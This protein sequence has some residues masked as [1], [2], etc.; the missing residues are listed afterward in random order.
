MD[1]LKQLQELL[2]DLFQRE[3][4]DLDFSLYRLLQLPVWSARRADKLLD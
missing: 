4:A 3:F 2:W 1:P